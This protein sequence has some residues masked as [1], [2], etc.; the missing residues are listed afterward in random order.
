MIFL[1]IS[2]MTLLPSKVLPVLTYNMKI[3]IS[4]H[5]FVGTKTKH[6]TFCTCDFLK[7]ESQLPR[8]STRKERM[9]IHKQQQDIIIIAQQR[10]FATKFNFAPYGSISHTVVKISLALT[11]NGSVDV[12]LLQVHIV[13]NG[14]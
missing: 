10:V 14:R 9:K 12:T 1:Q 11:N 3:Q 7:H 8:S 5:I 13:N 2:D 4:N 6:S